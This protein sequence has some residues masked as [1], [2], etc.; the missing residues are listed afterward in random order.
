MIFI[1]NEIIEPA[2]SKKENMAILSIIILLILFAGILLKFTITKKESKKI[3]N[4]Q[5]LSTSL[6]TTENTIFTELQIFGSDFQSIME[7][8]KEA[9]TPEF[10][11]KE[12]AYPPFVKD[13]SWEAK[14]EHKW[15]MFFSPKTNE[16]YYLGISSHRYVAGDF[17]IIINVKTNKSIIKYSKDEIKN[18]TGKENVREIS[19]KVKLMKEI[20]AYTGEDLINDAKGK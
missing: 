1:K 7:E 14:G 5:I 13:A 3:E 16:I 18:I 8:F 12:Q 4:T 11:D 6:N 2:S 20:I 10:L 9:P 17:V 19:E 15:Y